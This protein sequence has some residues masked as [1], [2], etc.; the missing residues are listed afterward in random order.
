MSLTITLRM[1][2]TASGNIVLVKSHA[3]RIL[4]APQAVAT[5]AS[6]DDSHQARAQIKL[7]KL[8]L[9]KF[10]GDPIR[11]PEFWDQFESTID[12]NRHLADVDELKYLRIYLSGKAEGVISGLATTNESYSTAIHLLKERFGHK[13][14][15]VNDHMRRLLNLHKVRSCE[16]FDR[17]QRLYEEVQ[18]RVRSLRNLGVEEKEYGVLL[19]TAI[20]QNL[21][22][23][24]VLR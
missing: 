13:S 4:S 9:P 19:K 7:P 22:Q 15:I 20:I 1:R 17:L 5:H 14:L 21:P 24:V 3:E 16:D 10:N 2:L 12:Q 11:W 23:E 18:T 8:D 6:H